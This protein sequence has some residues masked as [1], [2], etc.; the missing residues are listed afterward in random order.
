MGKPGI[1]TIIMSKKR[2]IKRSKP[3]RIPS[4]AQFHLILRWTRLSMNFLSSKVCVLPLMMSMS[5][6]F[7]SSVG[8]VLPLM[9]SLFNVLHFAL[10]N[11]Q[12]CTKDLNCI[13]AS[14]WT[15]APPPAS[16][17]KGPALSLPSTRTVECPCS[18]SVAAIHS[19]ILS[20][21]L[22]VFFSTIIT[23]AITTTYTTTIT[24][25]TKSQGGN[26]IA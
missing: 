3:L 15:T 12:T 17:C 6:N 9:M 24:K 4:T 18:S 11:C 23:T 25:T 2:F 10:Q 16:P 1:V 19:A 8:C 5:M 21:F 20:T 14:L 7:L 26:S 13:T 22:S